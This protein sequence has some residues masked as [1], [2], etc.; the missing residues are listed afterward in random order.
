MKGVERMT[1][2]YNYYV[3]LLPGHTKEKP[4]GLYRAPTDNPLYLEAIHSDGEWHFPPHLVR[5][6]T[7]G[8]TLDIEEIDKVTAEKAIKYIKRMLEERNKKGHT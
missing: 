7:R 4:A 1:V 6:F 8:D 2:K 3:D 5:A